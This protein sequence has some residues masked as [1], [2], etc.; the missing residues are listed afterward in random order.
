MSKL[1]VVVIVA[2]SCVPAVKSVLRRRGKRRARSLTNT[3]VTRRSTGTGRDDDAHPP[4]R[5]SGARTAVETGYCNRPRP[6]SRTYGP[7]HHRNGRGAGES[8]YDR[9]VV[10]WISNV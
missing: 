1:P 3:C 4:P 6:T 5:V 10:Q 9:V 2:V 8:N 7:V